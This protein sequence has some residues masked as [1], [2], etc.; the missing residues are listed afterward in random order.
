MAARLNDSSISAIG[1][2]LQTFPVIA[3][4]QN[5]GLCETAGVALHKPERYQ[6]VV[7]LSSIV[8]SS[9]PNGLEPG[10]PPPQMIQQLSG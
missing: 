7:V 8:I 9:L 6:D 10:W 3:G 1:A 5:D 4:Q 2:V